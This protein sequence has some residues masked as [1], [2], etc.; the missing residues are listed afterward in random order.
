MTTKRIVY[1]RPDGGVSVVCPAPNSQLPGESE[2]QWLDRIALW[3]VPAGLAS[4]IIEG[5]DLPSRR[6]RN[7]WRK[8]GAAVAVDLPLARAQVMTETRR[9][10]DALLLES[11]REKN[12]LDDVG[13]P[14]QRET[15]RAYRQALR[16]LPSAVQSQVDAL[17]TVAALDAFAP[18]YPAPPAGGEEAALLRP[19]QTY[20]TYVEVGAAPVTLAIDV[21]SVTGSYIVSGSGP[22]AGGDFGPLTRGQSAPIAGGALRVEVSVA[23]VVTLRRVSGSARREVGLDLFVIHGD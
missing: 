6:F 10:R 9:T 15:L 22:I 8:P 20:P 16:D 12:R 13:D 2:A 11:D 18:V 23:G 3:D 19:T 5:A 4:T 17:S 7:A 14:A 1:V 21:R